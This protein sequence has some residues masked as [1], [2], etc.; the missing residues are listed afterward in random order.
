MAIGDWV[1]GKAASAKEWAS[2]KW[3][4]RDEIVADAKEWAEEKAEASWEK[5]KEVKEYV[6]EKASDTKEWA[7]EK[8]ED[9]ERASDVASGADAKSVNQYYDKR[10]ELKEQESLLRKSV[11]KIQSLQP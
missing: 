4:E 11:G 5:A 1:R 3:D 10:H 8:I 2:E 7:G 6:G 9:Y